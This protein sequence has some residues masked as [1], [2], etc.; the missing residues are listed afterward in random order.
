MT[1]YSTTS[2]EGLQMPRVWIKQDI[3]DS[4]QVTT[5]PNP[6][7]FG[8]EGYPV[9]MNASLYRQIVAADKQYKKFQ[10]ILVKFYM[11]AEKHPSSVRRVR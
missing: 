5:E 10:N 6:D 7:R 3:D 8:Y 9:E 1:R 11:E 4:W 2:L